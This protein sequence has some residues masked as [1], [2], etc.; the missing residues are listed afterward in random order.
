[1]PDNKNKQNKNPQAAPQVPPEPKP[2]PQPEVPV[3]DMSG[4]V[5]VP[6]IPL[7]SAEDTSE[8][9]EDGFKSAFRFGFVGSGQGGARIT[10]AF[11]ALG[12]NRVCTVNMTVQ[13]QVAIQIPD[14]NKLEIGTSGA[15]K[16]PHVAEA[17]IKGESLRVMLKKS[18]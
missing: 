10:E 12:Y 16:N 6:D 3:V 8:I 9:I 17:K 1:M 15:G 7:P 2:E 14:D 13:D 18:G 5:A 11:H 4:V